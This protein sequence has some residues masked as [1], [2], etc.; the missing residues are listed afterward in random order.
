MA[1][2]DDKVTMEF[3]RGEWA[4]LVPLLSAGV[5]SFPLLSSER[6]VARELLRRIGE[7]EV[8]DEDEQATPPI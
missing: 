1:A 5:S 2:S 6:R 3:T 7:K 4:L 8:S